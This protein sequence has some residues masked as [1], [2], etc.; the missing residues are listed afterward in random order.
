[1][2]CKPPRTAEMQ[3]VSSATSQSQA[4]GAGRQLSFCFLTMLAAVAQLQAEWSG[5]TKCLTDFCVDVKLWRHSA[6]P[7]R[8]NGFTSVLQKRIGSSM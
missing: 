7:L 3:Q 1:M 6:Q 2:W 5:R 8:R 4:G